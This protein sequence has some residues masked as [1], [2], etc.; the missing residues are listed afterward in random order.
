[1]VFRMPGWRNV[2]RRC[3]FP[4]GSR[5]T[6]PTWRRSVAW[7]YVAFIFS[8]SIFQSERQG[9]EPLFRS[10]SAFACNPSFSG[11][12]VLDTVDHKWFFESCYRCLHNVGV[13]NI[14]DRFRTSLSACCQRCDVRNSSIEATL[15]RSFARTYRTRLLSSFLVR[16][17]GTR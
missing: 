5:H 9:L 16:T 12:N 4:G 8:F 2:P 1:M 7:R 17:Q 11:F 13:S 15:R 14:A 6:L 3:S 10:N